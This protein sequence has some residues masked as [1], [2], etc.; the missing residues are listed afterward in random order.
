[1]SELWTEDGVDDR[2]EGGVEVA[3]PE[4]ERYQVLVD[5]A[6]V[7]MADGHDDGDNEEGKPATDERAGDDGQRFGRLAFPLGVGGLFF[8]HLRRSWKEMFNFTKTKL[9]AVVFHQD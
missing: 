7:S 8:P 2:I 5:G 6:L 1:M 4:E 3:Q 9:C